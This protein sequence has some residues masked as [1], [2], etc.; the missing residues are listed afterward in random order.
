MHE[1]G[2]EFIEEL[3]QSTGVKL[4]VMWAPTTTL[5]ALSNN[6]TDV[7]V[8]IADAFADAAKQLGVDAPSLSV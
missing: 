8:A 4:G 2:R 5:G 3:Y 7:R 1:R 6:Q